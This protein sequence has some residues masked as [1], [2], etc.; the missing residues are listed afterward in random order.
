[1]ARS[2]SRCPPAIRAG[3]EF[4]FNLD[5]HG[6]HTLVAFRRLALSHNITVRRVPDGLSWVHSPAA[7]RTPAREKA[8]NHNLPD[9]YHL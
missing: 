6:S 5:A 8:L 9:E 4:T 3:Q 1:M 2:H 7:I